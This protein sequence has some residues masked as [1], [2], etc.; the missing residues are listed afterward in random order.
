MT[1]KRGGFSMRLTTQRGSR[2][3]SAGW[4]K[5]LCAEAV[6]GSAVRVEPVEPVRHRLREFSCGNDALDRWLHAYAGQAQRRDLARTYVAIDADQRVVGYYTLV[7]GQVEHAEAPAQVRAGVSRHFPI[8]IALIA[9]LAVATTH[10]GQGMGTDLVRDA[11]LRILS[12]SEQIGIR[13][14]LVHAVDQ[15][16]ASF[17]QRL[18]FD[19]ATADGLT[20]M[21]PLVAV[22]SALS[23]EP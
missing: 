15:S 16:A 7:A 11:F 12:A 22:R 4:L 2:K 20:L 9:R 17:Y 6:N 13:A 21:V 1:R 10:Q 23:R 19:G 8:P 14:V 18:G 3:G 5:R